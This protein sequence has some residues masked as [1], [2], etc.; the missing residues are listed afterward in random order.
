[1]INIVDAGVLEAV[2]LYLYDRCSPHS[3]LAAGAL[4]VA[5]ASTLGMCDFVDI[6][7]YSILSGR[8]YQI[9]ESQRDETL[10]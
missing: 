4:G 8:Q 9:R 6:P 2:V 5:A 3:S 10:F 7:I 1:M